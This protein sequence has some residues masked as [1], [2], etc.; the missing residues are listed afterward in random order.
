MSRIRTSRLFLAACAL[1]MVAASCS[2]STHQG[3]ATSP[4]TGH[5]S[6]ASSGA[7]Y[8]IGLLTDQTGPLSDTA[9]TTVNG[10]K[11]AVGMFNAEG[12]HL[13]YVVADTASSPSGALAGAQRLVEQDHVFAVDLVSGLGFAAEP[14]LVSK[15]IPVI[16][17]D[18]DGGTPW[19]SARNMF[20]SFGS[21]N[22]HDV[23][24]TIGLILK[25]L[26]AKNF[27]SIGYSISPSSSLNAKAAAASAQL[28]GIKVGYLNSQLPYGSTNV[29]PEVIAMKNAGVDSLEASTV[30]STSLALIS[31]LR[32][33]GAHL[34]AP[35]LVAGYGTL[36]TEGAATQAFAKGGYI[37]FPF[38][39]VELHTPATQRLVNA[40]MTYAGIPSNRID[41][42]AYEGY[43]SV[44]SFVAGL[45]KA[46]N[47]RP[48]QAQFID[49]MLSI[50]SYNAAGLYGS[51]TIGFAM[52]QRGHGTAGADNCGWMVR[53]DG[54]S[55]TLVNGMQPLC[56]TIVA[57]KSVS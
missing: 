5:A 3:N 52:D 22:F 14:Y 24:T 40:L 41:E 27:A 48:T 34:V 50:R 47:S 17:A 57:G 33:A 6:P 55:F 28:A 30:Q 31:G 4:S 10:V 36:P 20:S 9:K 26:G 53:W 16:G 1:V 56:G 15:G 42:A 2:S 49:A 35:I 39:P 18:I 23:E 7:T 12:Y 44:D 8:T 29:G 46:G 19:I 21:P 25:K 11:A 13:N 38:E 37:P 51:H 54:S 32:T 43:I 45:K